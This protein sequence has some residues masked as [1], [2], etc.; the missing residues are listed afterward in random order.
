IKLRATDRKFNIELQRA[1]EAEG[2]IHIA[3]VIAYGA[4]LRKESRGAH[5]RTDFPKRNDEEWMKHTMAFYNGEDKPKMEYKDVIVGL[6]E[7]VER[8]Y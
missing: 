6:W 1:L 7:V 2:M 3:E 4:Y 8:K 5:F